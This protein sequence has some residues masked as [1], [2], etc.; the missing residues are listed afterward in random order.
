MERLT[1]PSAVNALNLP[2]G[3]LKTHIYLKVCHS[4]VKSPGGW[5]EW[6]PPTVTPLWAAIIAPGSGSFLPVCGWISA[7]W[8]LRGASAHY[9]VRKS[10]FKLFKC[11]A[12]FTLNALRNMAPDRAKALSITAL[13]IEGQLHSWIWTNSHCCYYYS[14]FWCPSNKVVFQLEN[15]K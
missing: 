15:Y 1:A 5:A 3:I 4:P 6:A 10:R 12:G 11:P 14:S 9:S 7:M 2:R 13:W 8:P